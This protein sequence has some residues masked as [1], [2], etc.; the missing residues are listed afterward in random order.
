MDQETERKIKEENKKLHNFSAKSYDN[1]PSYI[2]QQQ[3]EMYSKDIKLMKLYLRS[4]DFRVLD[5]GCGTGILANEFIKQGITNV[6]CLDISNEMVKITM[7]KTN[8][9]CNYFVGDMDIHFE[10]INHKYDVI[11]FTSVLHHIGDYYKTLELAISRLKKGGIIYI[12]DEPQYGKRHFSVGCNIIQFLG[13]MY[14][15]G[16]RACKNPKHALK[17]IMNKFKQD[18]SNIDVGLAEY[19]ATRGGINDNKLLGYF[20]RQK[21]KMVLYRQYLMNAFKFMDRFNFL[22]KNNPKTFSIMVRKK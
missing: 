5:C 6:H 20:I 17:F 1:Y 18:D 11:C 15:N 19:H 12:A 13:I 3:M 22:Y 7:A 14:I 2:L 16:R 4:K 10:V 8:H 21:F 9:L